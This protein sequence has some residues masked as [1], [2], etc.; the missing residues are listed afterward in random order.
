MSN[1]NQELKILGR[2]KTSANGVPVVRTPQFPGVAGENLSIEQVRAIIRRQKKARGFRFGLVAG[3]NAD[4]DIQISGDARTF[5]GFAVLFENEAGGAVAESMTLTVNDEIVI[6]Q[7]PP[8]FFTPD[9]MDDEYYFFPR[10]LSGQDDINLSIDV[11]AG[12]MDF[13]LIVYYI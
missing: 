5:L 6:N 2:G 1:R 7:V 8:P 3:T 9:F 13:L 12:T 4:N 10:P 11:S